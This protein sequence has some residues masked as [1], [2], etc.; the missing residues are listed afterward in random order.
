MA[1]SDKNRLFLLLCHPLAG[2]ESQEWHFLTHT[3][4]SIN[5][6]TGIPYRDKAQADSYV[7]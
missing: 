1:N 5:I 4:V 2:S 7:G 6:S 3:W